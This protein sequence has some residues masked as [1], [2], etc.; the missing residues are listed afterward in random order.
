[1]AETAD[2]RTDRI[3]EALS[4][5]VKRLPREWDEL[6]AELGDRDTQLGVA[7]LLAAFIGVQFT[8][9]GPFADA[10]GALVGLYGLASNAAGLVSAARLA[11]SA[12]TNQQLD[13]AADKMA[14]EI[15]SLGVTAVGALL[16]FAAFRALKSAIKAVRPKILRG[17]LFEG[18]AGTA[19]GAGGSA[20]E[21][22]AI[23]PVLDVVGGA[24]AGATVARGAPT[25]G[26]QLVGVLKVGVPV[27]GGLLL[28]G[29]LLKRRD[30][31]GGDGNGRIRL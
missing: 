17:R 8:P 10:V 21:G 13:A 30:R 2:S 31:Q 11:A 22:S 25:V 3:L 23:T 27:V 26:K 9:A 15:A 1:M 28:I 6:K 4:R 14:D 7:V 29:Y 16:G 19:E 20:A 12:E 24:G 18:A 5:A